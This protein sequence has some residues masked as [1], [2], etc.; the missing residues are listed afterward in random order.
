MLFRSQDMSLQAAHASRHV[1]FAATRG[2]EEQAEKQ[3]LTHYFSG[4]AH[5][6][7]DKSGKL[8]LKPSSQQVSMVSQRLSSLAANAQPGGGGPAVS[9]LRTEFHTA[10]NGIL[11]IS[12]LVDVTGQP[13]AESIA[14]TDVTRWWPALRRQTSILT[15]AGH[16]SDDNQ[17]QQRLAFAPTAWQNS[18]RVSY[19][20][21]SKTDAA[22]KAVD[23]AWARDSP[24]GEWQ[25]GRA[26]V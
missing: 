14:I 26:H 3:T 17:V 7:Q 8:L 11:R 2:F 13:P 25:I 23:G 20:L 9:G 5:Q 22:M 24:T 6:W 4:P 10:D 18:S 19:Q 15:G 12:S 16:A 1:A 21:A